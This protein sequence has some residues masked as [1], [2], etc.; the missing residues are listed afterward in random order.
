MSEIEKVLPR[1]LNYI[2][3]WIGAG[4]QHFFD[5]TDPALAALYLDAFDSLQ[6]KCLVRYDEGELYMLTGRGFKIARALKKQLNP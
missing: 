4:G 6:R 3:Y 2:G 1:Y 5:Q